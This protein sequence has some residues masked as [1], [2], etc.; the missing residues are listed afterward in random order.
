MGVD[1]GA[2]CTKLRFSRQLPDLLL[3]EFTVVTLIRH[4]D[5]VDATRD[6]DANRFKGGD[7]VRTRTTASTNHAVPRR[8]SGYTSAVATHNVTRIVNCRGSACT[9]RAKAADRTPNVAIAANATDTI[10]SNA[11]ARFRNRSASANR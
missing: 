5:R 7:L 3:A 4:Q 2:E 9:K 1:L 11:N 8:K 6:D 10:A